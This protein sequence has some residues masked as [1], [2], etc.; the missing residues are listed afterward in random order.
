MSLT[1]KLAKRREGVGEE[2]NDKLDSLV[3]SDRGD[4]GGV[5][6]GVGEVSVSQYTPH[7]SLVGSATPAHVAIASL[8]L[9]SHDLQPLPPILPLPQP[10]PY[11]S[12][13]APIPPGPSFGPDS[14][15]R[16]GR[17]PTADTLSTGTGY[18]S[19]KCGWAPCTLSIKGGGWWYVSMGDGGG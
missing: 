11:C 15:G 17:V 5:G 4:G 14:W 1:L 2:S 16:C 9:A 3:M 7:S 12:H 8:H 6:G 10:T 18:N 13:C 19:F